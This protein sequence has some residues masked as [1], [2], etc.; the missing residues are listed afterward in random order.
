MYDIKEMTGG[1]RHELRWL[2]DHGL[3]A[4]LTWATVDEACGKVSLRKS[5]KFWR[6]MLR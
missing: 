1:W 5:A 2:R 3:K 4:W 6:W